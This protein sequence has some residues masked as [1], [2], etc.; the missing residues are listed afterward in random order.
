M[1]FVSLAFLDKIFEKIDYILT[2]FAA[3]C[4]GNLYVTFIFKDYLYKERHAKQVI[5][6]ALKLEKCRV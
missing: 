4:N 1:Y 5:S 6:R 3:A 2:V